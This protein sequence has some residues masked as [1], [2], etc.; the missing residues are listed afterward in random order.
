MESELN[1]K[2]GTALERPRC[3]GGKSWKGWGN[4]S[5]AHAG[6]AW[7]FARQS[8]GRNRFGWAGPG[9]GGP[10]MHRLASVKGKGGIPE[11]TR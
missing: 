10:L 9:E 4:T 7:C 5:R 8:P 6:R 2:S 11:C 1:G 3:W